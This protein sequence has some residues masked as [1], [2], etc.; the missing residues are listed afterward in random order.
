MQSLAD[1]G[2]SSWIYFFYSAIGYNKFSI[3]LTVYLSS[4]TIHPT[5]K[6]KYWYY[7][8]LFVFLYTFECLCIYVNVFLWRFVYVYFRKIPL[9]YHHV[10][11]WGVTALVQHSNMFWLCLHLS[12]GCGKV[13]SP[14]TPHM[15]QTLHIRCTKSKCRW[16][17]VH[18]CLYNLF[19]C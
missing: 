18:F 17:R 14:Y 5:Q 2:L 12:G 3:P 19:W 7:H 1:F 6:Y 13:R 10:S 11:Q 4:F 8:S 15:R 9:C 16:H